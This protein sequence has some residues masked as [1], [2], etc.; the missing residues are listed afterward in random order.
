MGMEAS[1]KRWEILLVEDNPADANLFQM[2][3]R[4]TDDIRVH[5]SCVSDGGQALNFLH[6]RAEHVEAPRPDLIFLDLN[7]PI[8]DGREV[9]ERVKTDL[10][11]VDIPIIVLSTSGSKIDISQSYQRGANS[12]MVKPADVNTLFKMIHECRCYWFQTVV[13]NS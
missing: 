7:L 2:A 4:D 9:L 11:L 6:K 12:Y 13:L 1:A 5:V 3:M 8:V 10:R